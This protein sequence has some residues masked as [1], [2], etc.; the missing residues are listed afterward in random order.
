MSY[1]THETAEHTGQP[2]EMLFFSRGSA[3]WRYTTASHDITPPTY[4]PFDGLYVAT[5]IKRNAIAQSSESG[6]NTLT[7]EVPRDLDLLREFRGVPLPGAIAVTLMRLQQRDDTFEVITLWSGRVLGASWG[8]DAARLEC[9]PASVSLARNG[10]RQLYARTCTHV[11]YDGMC[12]AVPAPVANAVFDIAGNALVLAP[13]SMQPGEFAGGWV[14]AV[15][16]EKKTMIVSNTDSTLT[17]LS[18]PTFETGEPV[19]LYAGCDKTMATCQGKFNNLPNYGGFPFIPNK[20][21]FNAGV[22]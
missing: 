17:L 7:L 16:G 13:S 19:L 22:F 15:G 11:L 14:E 3:V 21:P 12:K 4:P 2:V 5:A 18:M 10:L 1:G 8:A 9:E 20:N 6:R